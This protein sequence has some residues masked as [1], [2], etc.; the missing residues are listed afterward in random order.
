MNLFTGVP[1][2]YSKKEHWLAQPDHPDKAVDLIFL[3]PSSCHDRKAGVICSVDNKS[4]RKGARRNFAN[5][6]SVFEPV[7]NL[8]APYWRQVNAMMLSKMS[9]KDVDEAAGKE[10]W[11]D[12][13]AALDY[14][15]THL[16]QG[17]PYILAGHSQGS[18][19]CY[20]VLSRYMK[21]HP[22]YYANMIAA[23]CMQGRPVL[24]VFSCEGS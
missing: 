9:F 17:R 5:Q 19:M 15:F 18:R 11:T 23:Y 20:M 10:P 2:D 24:S 3:Y 22:E 16:N 21:E 12:V 13:Y 4:M 7:A 6:A 1:T 8:F 14:Y